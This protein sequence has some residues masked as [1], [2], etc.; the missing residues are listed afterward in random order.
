MIAALPPASE[1]NAMLPKHPPGPIPPADIKTYVRTALQIIR[2]RQ[3]RPAPPTLQGSSQP[4]EPSAR[5][6]AKV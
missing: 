1:V 3:Q 2:R 4:V 5:E 6:V